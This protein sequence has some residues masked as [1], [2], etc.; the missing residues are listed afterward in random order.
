ME[1]K[2]KPKRISLGKGTDLTSINLAYAMKLLSLPRE[3]GLDPETDKPVSAGLGRFGPYVERA[4][5]FASIESVDTL[6]TI[7][8]DEALERIRNKNSKTVLKDLGTHPE[9]GEPL[10]VYKGRYGPYVTSGK[11]NA[12]IG[13]DRDPSEVTVEQALELLKA[14]AERNKNGGGKKA[15]TKKPAKKKVA[16]KKVA[17]KAGTKKVVAKKTGTKKAATKKTGTKKAAA[18]KPAPGDA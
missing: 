2:T 13:R 7:T 4:R 6:F 15:P 1:G 18:G 5:V 14:A 9:T 8:L 16:N 17:K 3:I 12:T 11:V 10:A